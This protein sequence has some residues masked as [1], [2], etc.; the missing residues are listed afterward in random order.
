M[1]VNLE[2][3]TDEAIDFM[4][5]WPTEQMHLWFKVTHPKTGVEGA[6]YGRTYPRSEDGY[7]RMGADIDSAQGRANIYYPVNELSVRLQDTNPETGEPFGKAGNKHIT[8]VVA[9]HADIDPKGQTLDEISAH[10]QDYTI[11]PSRT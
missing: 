10:V 5:A 11:H 4:R 7:A 8:R 6:S 2:P 3:N 1:S 9:F